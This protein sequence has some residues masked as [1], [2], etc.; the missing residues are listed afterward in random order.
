MAIAIIL[1][2][3]VG[4]L[5]WYAAKAKPPHHSQGAE[6]IQPSQPQETAANQPQPSQVAQPDQ[7]EEVAFIDLETTGLDD[8]NDR[9]IEVALFVVKLGVSGH[10]DGYS[11]LANP[12][13]SIPQR[14]TELTGISDEMV[15]SSRPTGEVV[16]ELLD[17]IGER[18][19]AAYN[20]EF[21]IGFLRAEAARLNRKF[22]NSWVC[23]MQYAKGKHP[24]LPR[25]RLSDVCDA[26]GI[27]DSE[28]AKD[29]IG[30]HRALYDAER[31]LRLYI[32]ISN[33]LQPNPP[34]PKVSD[35]RMNY[36]ELDR[37]H[38]IRGSAKKL[39]AKSKEVEATD[40]NQAVFG[41]QS[42]IELLKEA[43]KI[44]IYTSTAAWSSPATTSE[45]GDID[46]LNRLTICLCKLKR[47]QDARSV[48]EDYF[49]AFPK[50]AELKTAEQIRKRV[51]KAGITA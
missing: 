24:N 44:E 7:P 43:G 25:Y 42:A 9:I 30:P 1:A 20:A 13:R 6:D 18:T 31:M 32:A 36:R 15:S 35:R 47:G 22:N 11:A 10:V 3:I 16:G 50:E 23:I 14:I 27:L 49:S 19:I 2:L 51:A 39:A 41:Y 45:T 12:G 8:E 37:Y 38:A 46:C 29:G 33:G 48:V 40:L 4:G 17:R 26:F 34:S 5:I 21:D 28:S